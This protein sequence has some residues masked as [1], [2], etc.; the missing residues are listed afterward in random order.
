MRRCEKGGDVDLVAGMGKN[1]G[2]G[3]LENQKKRDLS[4]E[5]KLGTKTKGASDSEEDEQRG[6]IEGVEGREKKGNGQGN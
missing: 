1:K 5:R 6:D 2:K 3:G 4:K